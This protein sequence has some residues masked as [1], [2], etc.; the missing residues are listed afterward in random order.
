MMVRV[1]STYMPWEHR[2]EIGCVV[3]DQYFYFYF[4]KNTYSSV[5]LR[6][7]N[8][9]VHMTRAKMV[10]IKSFVIELCLSCVVGAEESFLCTV[11]CEKVLWIAYFWNLRK[12]I[13]IQFHNNCC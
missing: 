13:I 4:F 9:K 7:I 1:L 11:G 5:D 8:T 12:E 3:E 2:G 6:N 10:L